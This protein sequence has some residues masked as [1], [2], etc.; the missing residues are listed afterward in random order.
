[1]HISRPFFIDMIGANNGF[2][3]LYAPTIAM[4]ILLTR[5]FPKMKIDIEGFGIIG[6]GFVYPH[7][8]QILRCNIV[9]KPLVSGLMNHDKIPFMPPSA[10]RSI[11]TQVTVLIFVTV[12][13]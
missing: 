13:N 12:S 7:V 11:P 4:Q 8:R 5:L 6:K 2:L 1:I 3:V 9:A 10:A